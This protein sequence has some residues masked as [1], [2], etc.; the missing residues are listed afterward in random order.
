MTGL[1][2]GTQVTI[3][4]GYDIK[5]SSKHAFDFL[6]HYNRMLP[7]TFYLHSTAET[8]N[9]LAGTSLP[10]STPFTT[11]AIPVPS[12]AGTPVAGMPTNSFNA[13]PAAERLMTCYN[14]TIDTIY[15][16]VQGSLTA[17]QSETQVSIKLTPTA[18]TAVLIWGGHLGSRADWGYTGTSP[19]S[20]GGISGSPFHM[21]LVG[22]S[23]GSVGNQDRSLA[24]PAVQPPPG[25][26]PVE[27][28]HFGVEKSGMINK[29]E[30]T[31]ASEINNDYFRLERAGETL[32]FQQ[33]AVVRGAGNATTVNEYSWIDEQPLKGISY[34]R[35]VQT[36]YDG[37]QE[38]F[39]PVSAHQAEKKNL[40]VVSAYP[41]PFTTKFNLIYHSSGKS[42]VQLDVLDADGKKVFSE[43]L[44]SSEGF[45]KY[46]L[47][48]D[49]II[50]DG[51]FFII[52]SQ[53][54]IKSDPLRVVKE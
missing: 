48:A 54:G 42:M 32:E 20:A 43:S 44:P 7:H 8:I 5:N 15:Y 12:A 3:T 1:A 10:A 29:V 21:R 16:V 33:V 6:T 39:G 50:A 35:L 37:H 52:F 53:D 49:K 24:G 9:P 31:T 40:L 47:P 4:I 51:V 28:I 30:W 26:L 14:G 22:W 2:I 46:E 11:Y 45:N 38:V 19:K 18:A 17:S 25:S 34:Y 23:L 41:N 36:D 27:L 13:I